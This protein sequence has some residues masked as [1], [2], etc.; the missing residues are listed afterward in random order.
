MFPSFSVCV[1]SRLMDEQALALQKVELRLT[2]MQCQQ[3]AAM[4]TFEQRHWAALLG[5]EQRLESRIEEGTIH[6][7]AALALKMDEMQARNLIL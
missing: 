3:T 5:N 7:V 2:S 4:I 1:Q 6:V